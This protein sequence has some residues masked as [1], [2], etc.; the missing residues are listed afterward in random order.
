MVTKTF[1]TLYR[2]I[3]TAWSAIDWLPFMPLRSKFI[4][5]GS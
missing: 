4:L 2:S 1:W 5:L 3:V